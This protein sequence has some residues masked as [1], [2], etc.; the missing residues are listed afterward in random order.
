MSPVGLPTSIPLISTKLKVSPFKYGGAF[1]FMRI[2]GLDEFLKK[3][4]L[5]K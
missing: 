3:H 4:D 2:T 5:I 1:C